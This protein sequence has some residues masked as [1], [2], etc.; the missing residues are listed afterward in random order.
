MLKS[1]LLVTEEDD[2]GDPFFDEDIPDRF[3]KEHLGTSTILKWHPHPLLEEKGS[4]EPA[5]LE[6][7]DR[8]TP[9]TTDVGAAS[10]HPPK[11]ILPAPP[12]WSIFPAG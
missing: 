2:D 11:S 10:C 12:P 8:S 3:N 9:T 7:G 1:G 4:A 5:S 6:V